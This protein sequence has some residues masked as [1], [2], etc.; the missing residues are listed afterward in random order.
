[1]DIPKFLDDYMRYYATTDKYYTGSDQVL[2]FRKIFFKKLREKGVI[3]NYST[4][5]VKL[6]ISTKY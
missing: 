1:M 4:F 2:I 3:R 6:R 5:L